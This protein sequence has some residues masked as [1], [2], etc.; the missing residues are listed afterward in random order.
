MTSSLLK[1]ILMY[2]GRVDTPTGSS[3]VLTLAPSSGES[4]ILVSLSV[5]YA[6]LGR[7]TWKTRT[8]WKELCGIDC[9]VKLQAQT[10]MTSPKGT[11]SEGLWGWA[12]A[13]TWT[14]FN[15]SAETWKWLS[16]DF[17][18][19]TWQSLGGSAE[20]NGKKIPKSRCAKLVASYPRRLKTAITAK[21][22]SKYWLLSKGSEQ[23][24][25]CDI[26]VLT[27]S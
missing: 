27:F 13:L 5:L 9:A 20:K 10:L 11:E 24:H 7:L 26:S 15:F 12:R 8:G 2:P 22:A 14:E 16:T 23:F 4:L 21:G 25:Q 3:G 17:H 6:G 18:N 19:S 1:Q